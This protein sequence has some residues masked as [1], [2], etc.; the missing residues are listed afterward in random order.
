MNAI[1]QS[2]CLPL[3]VVR[4]PFH[5]FPLG[6]HH[7]LASTCV[8]WPSVMRGG[9]KVEEMA[10]DHRVLQKLLPSFITKAFGGSYYLSFLK[11]RGIRGGHQA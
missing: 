6:P 1:A 2:A 10:A 9:G 4:A 5:M 8:H 7:F 3:P 11:E